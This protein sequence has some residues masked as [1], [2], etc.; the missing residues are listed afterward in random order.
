MPFFEFTVDDSEGMA[1]IDIVSSSIDARLRQMSF[2][3]FAHLVCAVKSAL[4][5]VYAMPDVVDL[6]DG[7][8]RPIPLFQFV[9]I[10]NVEKLART[11][12]LRQ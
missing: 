6:S 4:I 7:R 12:S 11:N 10:T 8:D 1:E 2:L 9:C 5:P 3:N